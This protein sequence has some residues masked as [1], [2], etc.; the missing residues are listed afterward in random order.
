[1]LENGSV[2][3]IKVFRRGIKKILLPKGAD[4]IFQASPTC[5]FVVW[6]AEYLHHRHIS[7]VFHSKCLA[8]CKNRIGWS[9]IQASSEISN[10][11]IPAKHMTQLWFQQFC[12]P[13][14]P[15]EATHLHTSL[16]LLDSHAVSIAN[17]RTPDGERV[18][19]YVKERTCVTVIAVF[20]GSLLLALNHSTFLDG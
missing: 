2:H 5:A 11:V 7:Y 3:Q 13:A 15:T 16:I 4:M 8:Q 12:S 14:V 17:L 20:T 9:H 19:E 18:I 1:M 6:A 10:T